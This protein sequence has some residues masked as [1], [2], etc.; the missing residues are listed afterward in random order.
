MMPCRARCAPRFCTRWQHP[1]HDEAEKA[2]P[3]WP[4]DDFEAEGCYLHLGTPGAGAMRIHKP[5]AIELEYVQ[6]MMV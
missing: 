6:R 2:T 1:S 5:L 4:G 3:N